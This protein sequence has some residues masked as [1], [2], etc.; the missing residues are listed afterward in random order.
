MMKHY[1]KK[2]HVSTAKSGV[3]KGKAKKVYT[4]KPLK[5]RK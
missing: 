2:H 1:Y 3:S 4:F 5:R